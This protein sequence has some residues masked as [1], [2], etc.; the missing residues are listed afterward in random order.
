MLG[1]MYF[2]LPYVIHLPL[3]AARCKLLLF[4]SANPHEKACQ[5]PGPSCMLVPQRLSAGEGVPLP[6]PRGS[7]TQVQEK[8]AAR[9]GSGAY[10]NHCLSFPCFLSLCGS[11]HRPCL[12][13]QGAVPRALHPY[14]PCLSLHRGWDGPPHSAWE[15]GQV[16]LPT[17]SGSV[18]ATSR[19]DSCCTRP[20]PRLR[21]PI[22][23]TI[24]SPQR[25]ASGQ[26]CHFPS[27]LAV[28]ELMRLQLHRLGPGSSVL[29]TAEVTVPGGLRVA[30]NQS[31]G[32]LA[33]SGRLVQL[34]V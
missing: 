3:T 33:R 17:L 28:P 32:I 25:R 29:A 13:S 9:E 11:Q 2:F 16:P 10:F 31:T 1:T 6:A 8:F 27:L 21:C 24:S 18:P 4:N 14:L 20:P 26:R 19:C 30:E 7:G 22:C 12:A 34:L 23:T 5:A 15:G